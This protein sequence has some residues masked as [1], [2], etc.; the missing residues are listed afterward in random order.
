[1]TLPL[2]RALALLFAGLFVL[3][4]LASIAYGRGYRFDFKT[5]NIRL[6]GVILLAGAP[7]RVQVKID[8]GEPKNVSLPT[9][10]RGL[11]PT[12]HTIS[13]SAPGYE[14][15]IFTL[16]V[17]SGQTTFAT[18]IQ[19]YQ[20]S[21][22][23]TVR[24]GIP[25]HAILAPDGSAVAWLENQKITISDTTSV[26]HL[27]VALDV[28]SLTWS[29]SN[30]NLFAPKRK[31]GHARYREPCRNSSRKIVRLACWESTKD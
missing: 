6:T 5:R 30:D 16:N 31:S 21:P 1:M 29:E 13:L 12:T 22:F 2:R 4:A 3:V 18:D 23:T 11:L 25:K 17:R 20:G 19:L 10:F 14:S 28:E 9:T 8:D 26:K 27:T 7:D 24:T 15:Q